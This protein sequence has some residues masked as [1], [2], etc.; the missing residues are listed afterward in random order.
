MPKKGWPLVFVFVIIVL[1]VL[2][3]LTYWQIQIAREV[4]LE[5]KAMAKPASFF[6]NVTQTQTMEYYDHSISVNY[7]SSSPMQKIIV[8]VD[9]EQR[10]IEREPIA[11]KTSCGEY[12]TYNNLNLKIEPVTWVE[13]PEGQLVWSFETWNTNQ[14]YFSASYTAEPAQGGKML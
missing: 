8:T 13:N 5:E 12:W 1:V 11:C 4:Q 2:G 6:L 9:G 3:Y 10:A 14:I 7:V